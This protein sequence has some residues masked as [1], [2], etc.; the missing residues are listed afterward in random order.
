M[1]ASS[2]LLPGFAAE[3]PLGFLA[4]MGLLRIVSEAKSE[5]YPQLNWRKAGGW[6]PVISLA[7]HVS[8]DLLLDVISGACEQKKQDWEHLLKSEELTGN[9]RNLKFTRQEYREFALR[10]V[11]PSLLRCINGAGH[12]DYL[13]TLG[14]IAATTTREHL[15][16][17][18]HED[19]QFTDDGRGRSLRLDPAGYREHALTW[20]DPSEA[21]STVQLGANRLAIEAFPLFPIF[22]AAFRA[23]QR[24]FHYEGQRTW[25]RW[26]VWTVPYN[27]LTAPYLLDLPA[28]AHLRD[29]EE[30]GGSQNLTR[31][32]KRRREKQEDRQRENR[33]ELQRRGIAMVYESQRIRDGKYFNFGPTRAIPI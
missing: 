3:N 18:L 14:R 27:V 15:R 17:T 25:F 4:V 28:I 11:S 9:K 8:E 16:T 23:R 13:P 31:E 26:P 1:K 22:P 5:W 12:Q 33:E 2:F 32:A 21:P 30:P 20:E 19:W 29:P 6:R 7:E 10:L 24:G